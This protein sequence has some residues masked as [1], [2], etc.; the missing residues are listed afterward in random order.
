[1]EIVE[2]F[3]LH[4]CVYLEYRTN[5]MLR[6]VESD[7]ER[8]ITWILEGKPWWTDEDRREGRFTIVL[9]DILF[10]EIHLGFRTTWVDELLA[11][12]DHP[13]LRQFTLHCRPDEA[14][15]FGIQESWVICKRG[16]IEFMNCEPTASAAQE[17]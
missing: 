2:F 6:H 12:R 9:E 10:T 16:S 4:P 7:G 15:F 14:V 17:Q 11:S 1:M 8:R 5:L 13:K 3:R